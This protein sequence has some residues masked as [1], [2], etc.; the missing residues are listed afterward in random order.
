MRRTSVRSWRPGTDHQR[1]VPSGPDPVAAGI[2]DRH[3]AALFSL[4]VAML[5]DHQRA[6]TAVVDAICAAYRSPAVAD[7]PADDL[8]RD[9]AYRLYQH[10]EGAAAVESGTPRERQL[11]AMALVRQGGL[12]YRQVADLLRVSASDVI[13]LLDAGLRGQIRA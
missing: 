10:C 6:E 1:E 8:R 7:V 11:V 4:A 9:L 13:E 3:G 12:T 5:H 2:C